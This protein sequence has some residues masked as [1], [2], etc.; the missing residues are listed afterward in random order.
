[1]KFSAFL[2]NKWLFLLSQSMIILFL[3]VLFDGLQ[4]SISLTILFL[5]CVLMITVVSLV[6][7]Y[8]RKNRFYKE[9]YRNLNELD[10]KFYISSMTES[11]EFIE[12][13][14]LV[15]ILNQVSKSMNDEIAIYRRMNKEYHDYIETWIHEIKIPISC[16]DLMC[17]NDSSDL[18]RGIKNELSRIDSY[19][20]QALYYARGM[21]LEKDYII[22]EIEL[23]ALVKNCIK[24]YSKQLIAVKAE[25]A[26]EHLSQTVYGDAKWL[27]FVLGQLV[28][29]SIKYR[30]GILKLSFYAQ[31]QPDKVVLFVRDN[32]IGIPQND[33]PRIF[34]KGFT[35]E[36]GRRFAKSTGIGLYLCHE[37]CDKMHLNI[38]VEATDNS[39][40]VISITF[41]KDSKL[42][43]EQ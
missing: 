20:E 25:L 1:M 21:N 10:K 8:Y 38:A 13:T 34:D 22:R 17:E 2:K 14:I 43:L 4:I 3:A 19:V 36:N 28:T 16:I 23:D 30:N 24:K 33:L 15:D 37:L 5:I 27:E 41:P 29:N 31:N 7:E 9:L 32:G 18:A 35:G 12:G 6:L 40:T 42:L 11:P 26:F 39:G